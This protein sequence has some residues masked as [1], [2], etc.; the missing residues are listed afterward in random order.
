MDE[1]TRIFGYVPFEKKSQLDKIIKNLKREFGKD[2]HIEK[3]M[4]HVIYQKFP[5]RKL[6][7]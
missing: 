1:T 7:L 5:E 2:I 4:D 3:N 6:V